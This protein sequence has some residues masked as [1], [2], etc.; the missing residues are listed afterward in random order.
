MIVDLRGVNTVQN[1]IC[2]KM[3]QARQYLADTS[4]PIWVSLSG[5]ELLRNIQRV[6]HG[7]SAY[8]DR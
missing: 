8:L 3:R 1:E 7:H 5:L 4:Q 6:Y 2:D